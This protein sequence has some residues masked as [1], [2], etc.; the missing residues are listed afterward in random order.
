MVTAVRL[1]SVLLAWLHATCAVG[2]AGAHGSDGGDNSSS[3][4]SASSIVVAVSQEC[5]VLPAEQSRNAFP[6]TRPLVVLPREA[7]N[8]FTTGEARQLHGWRVVDAG[9]IAEQRTKMSCSISRN[10]SHKF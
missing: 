8:E 3:V 7:L 6:F 4:E 10:I 5:A 9:T 2:L 1:V